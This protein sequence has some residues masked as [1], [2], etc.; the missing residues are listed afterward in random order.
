MSLDKINIKGLSLFK[1]QS[2]RISYL[3]ELNK[4]SLSDKNNGNI[5]IEHPIKRH[6]RYFAEEFNIHVHMVLC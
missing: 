6:L 3:G 4:T 5:L 2:K 1:C